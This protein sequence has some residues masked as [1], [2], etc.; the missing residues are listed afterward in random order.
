M[1]VVGPAEGTEGVTAV[2]A[3]PIPAIAMVLATAPAMA[4][5]FSLF[6]NVTPPRGQARTVA[7]PPAPPRGPYRQPPP[8]CCSERSRPVKD[9]VASLKDLV[10]GL[11][12]RIALRG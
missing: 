7:A 8:T 9:S 12:R 11:I 4:T 3:A 10:R 6:C 2:A 5:R 1:L